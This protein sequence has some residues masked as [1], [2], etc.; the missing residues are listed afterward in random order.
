MVHGG[1][2]APAWLGGGGWAYEHQ[3]ATGKLASG[4]VGAKE[5]RIGELHNEEGAAAV[6][7]GG[8]FDSRRGEA[9]R[10]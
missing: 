10:R 7:R 3:R 8:G 5:G 4:S 1:G 9:R 2:G 6:F